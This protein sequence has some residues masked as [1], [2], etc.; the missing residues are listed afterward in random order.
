MMLEGGGGGEL[1]SE[2]RHD[3]LQIRYRQDTRT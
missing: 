2:I 3:K 1:G